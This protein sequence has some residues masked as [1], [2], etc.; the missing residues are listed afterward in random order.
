[1]PLGR[2][3]LKPWLSRPLNME[4]LTS[5]YLKHPLAVFNAKLTTGGLL[6]SSNSCRK[7]VKGTTNK[8]MPNKPNGFLVKFSKEDFMQQ[9]SRSQSS[10]ALRIS[11]FTL[12]GKNSRYTVRSQRGYATMRLTYYKVNCTICPVP[13]SRWHGFQTC[14]NRRS[15]KKVTI[16]KTE[17]DKIQHIPGIQWKQME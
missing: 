2:K 1:M 15:T 12:S 11:Q 8:N 10:I 6:N 4:K 13:T 5:Q 7:K 14:T 17:E 3:P 9:V 16:S